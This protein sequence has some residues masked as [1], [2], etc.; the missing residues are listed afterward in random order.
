M[1]TKYSFTIISRLIYSVEGKIGK[2]I[3][4]ILF[5][6]FHL[7]VFRITKTT[8][9]LKRKTYVQATNKLKWREYVLIIS[10]R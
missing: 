3:K 1:C 4:K 10:G 8:T 5:A 6:P 7:I 9:I 2:T